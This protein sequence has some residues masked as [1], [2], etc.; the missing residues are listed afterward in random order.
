MRNINLKNIQFFVL[1]VVLHS[2]ILI[3]FQATPRR[4]ASQVDKKTSDNVRFTL[5]EKLKDIDLSRQ[6]KSKSKT[7]KRLNIKQAQSKQNLK[8]N[9]ALA[10]SGNKKSKK[11]GIGIK[12]QKN[13]FTHGVQSFL[14]DK[15]LEASGDEL[16]LA[17]QSIEQAGESAYRLKRLGKEVAIK[18][19]LELMLTEP[20]TFTDDL[21]M[22]TQINLSYS[23]CGNNGW[24]L[25]SYSGEMVLAK[26]FNRQVL[27]SIGMNHFNRIL[28]L[29]IKRFHLLIQVQKVTYL[30]SV[31]LKEFARL[32]S[33][34]FRVAW[35][36]PAFRDLKKG[37]QVIELLRAAEMVVNKYIR[38]EPIT[39]SYK[40]I[41][42][43]KL[44]NLKCAYP[45]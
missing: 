32:G 31:K 9:N 28:G 11:L 26:F 35:Q 19:K 41:M 24:K 7:T 22:N 21:A 27:S 13:L 25:N 45:K 29:G 15:M 40:T 36:V 10:R 6:V 20:D 39:R 3:I 2:L 37:E 30:Q 43:T 4:L 18:K 44:N 23:K 5:V 8:K 38:K 33:N 14:N 34:R 1:S 12:K 42:A 17:E 16:G